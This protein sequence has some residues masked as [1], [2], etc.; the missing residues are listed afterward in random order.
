VNGDGFGD[1][2]VGAI[3]ADGN[4]SYAGA[5][6]VIFG[7]APG[8]GAVFNLNG[9]DGTNGFRLEGATSL[10]RAGISVSSAGDV[11]GDGFDDVLVGAAFANSSTGVSYVVFGKASGFA[12]IINL[13]SLDGTTGFRLDGVAPG[14]SSGLSVNA[15]GDVNGD[16]FDDLIVG[17]SQADPHATNSG[18]S[19]VLFGGNFTNAV[20]FLGDAANNSFTGTASAE[21][22]VGGLGNDTFAG[23]GGADAFDGGAGNDLI[24][25]GALGFQR[26]DGGGNDDRLLFE[27]AVGAA[28]DLTNVSARIQGIEQLDFTNGLAN[29]IS[30]EA[31]DVLAL[32]VRNDDAGGV[33]GLDNA[34]K[35]LGD[36]ADTVDLIGAFTLESGGAP[37]GFDVYHFDAAPAAKVVVQQGVTVI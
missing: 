30:I 4:G 6:Y 17:A 22:F 25:V 26:A 20:T 16:G 15:A 37:A 12:A 19:Y 21:R 7:H 10:D 3:G 27:A 9:L 13:A 14:D 24:R 2:I 31:R 34:V 23:N 1:L 28:I 36:G 33:S 18:S 32:H 35:I 8:F 5:S 11:N 29:T